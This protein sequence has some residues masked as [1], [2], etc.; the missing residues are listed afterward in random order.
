MPSFAF[1][2]CPP[3]RRS[4]RIL[5]IGVA[6]TTLT[7]GM[8]PSLVAQTQSAPG[9][10]IAAGWVF[11]PSISVAE[12]FDNNVLLTS[13][14]GDTN[15][16]FVTALVP[17][18]ALSFRGRQVTLQVD[19][20]GSYQLYQQLSELNAFDQR[21]NLSY[22]QRLTPRVSLFAR[23]SLSK[24]PTTD[25]VNVPGVPFRR[26]GVLIDDARAGVEARL[27]KRTQMSGAY[28][29]QLIEFEDVEPV[30]INALDRSGHAHGAVAEV[31]HVVTPRL[32][33]GG[34]YE[35]RL[36][37]VDG[38]R[39]F[40]MQNALATADYRLSER[41]NI[42]GAVGYSWLTRNRL[43]EQ[44]RSAP[45]FR[46]DVSRSGSR[47]AWNVGYRRSFLPSVGFGGTFEN[48]EFQASAL[49]SLTRRLDWSGGVSVLE[50]DPLQIDPLWGL[51]RSLRTVYARSSLSYLATRFL[52]IEGF[53]VA[54]FQDTQRAG[55]KID[56]SRAGVRVVTST[57][58]R[59]R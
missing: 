28:T 3:W 24:S 34:E 50:A 23:N 42:S 26:Q 57:R 21:A 40:D 45:A 29:F 14:G 1:G 22:R 17:G 32:T 7:P 56:R 12:T 53:Y 54:A 39:E 43:L 31:D 5:A 35:L 27:N 47:L 59:I 15:S 2:P 19:Y 38:T 51:D 37:T 9:Q 46:L 44:Q 52:R 18:A 30:I 16:D 33:L 48:Q 8:I 36:A 13:E 6:V 41:F 11:T 55:G 58:M 49:A 10:P 20:L 25:E 4:L